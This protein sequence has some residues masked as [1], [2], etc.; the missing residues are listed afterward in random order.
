MGG[1]DNITV[2]VIK[3]AEPKETVWKKVKS[4]LFKVLLTIVGYGNGRK[5]LQEIVSR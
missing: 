1:K 5:L 4:I 3:N 2:G